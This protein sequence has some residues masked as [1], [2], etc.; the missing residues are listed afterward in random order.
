M[1]TLW[2]VALVVFAVAAAVVLA[3]AV[4]DLAVTP[5]F[6]ALLRLVVEAVAAA[7]VSAALWSRSR[8]PGRRPGR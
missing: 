3:D 7:V 8:S 5:S 6:A 4:R 1:H 2:T